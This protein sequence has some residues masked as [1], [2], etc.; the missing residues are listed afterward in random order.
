MTARIISSSSKKTVVQIEIEWGTSMLE[1]ETRI[2]SALNEAGVAATELILKR[3]DTSG[4]PIRFGSVSMTSKGEV[5]CA[6]QTPYGEVSV[7]RHVYQ[8]SKGGKTFCPLEQNARILLSATPLFAKQ[9]SH[10][11]AE[12]G[13][14]RVTIDLEENHGRRV[15]RSFVQNIADAVAAIAQATEE[16][17]EYETPTQERSVNAVSIGI[18]GT[19]MLTVKDGWRQ[20]MVGTIALHSTDGERLHTIYL[21]AT[22]EY[23]KETFI[24][25]MERE[26]SRVRAL[27]P[28]ALFIG[29]ADGA[30]D[31]WPFLE[32]HTDRQLLDFYHASEYLTKVADAVF[33]KDAEERESWLENAC[34]RLKHNRTGPAALLREM[35]DYRSRHIGPERRDILDDCITYFTNQKKR[36]NYAAHVEEN[37]PIGSGITEAACKVIVKQ[38]LCGSGM[39][40]KEQGAAAVLSL[41][42]L[43]YTT[44]RWSQFW[45][46][47]DISGFPL[48]A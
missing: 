44:G 2:Q 8:T 20:A 24:A 17:W 35:K 40:W 22:P 6:Y 21:G 7:P 38:R 11:Y 29:L 43:S 25:R 10:K 36:M 26:I 42:T 15:A 23:G 46:K 33:F 37:L 27:F 19:C 5:E 12:H 1:S 28:R 14:G 18:D 41:R 34:H 32:K 31:N 47:I 3:F 16:C 9:L 13:A 48:V 30:K 45:Q 4:E 39:R